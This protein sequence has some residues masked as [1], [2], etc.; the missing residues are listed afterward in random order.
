[1]TEDHAESAPP[2]PGARRRILDTA[3]RLFYGEGIHSVGIDRIIAES[4]VSKASFYKYFAAKDILIAEYLARRHERSVAEVAAVSR[5]P[6][7]DAVRGVSALISSAVREPGF[8]GCAFVNA[9][10]EYPD[11]SHLVR[12]AITIHRDW[13][14]EAMWTLLREAGHPLPGDAADDFVLARDGA[15]TGGYSGDAIAAVAALERVTDR[16]LAEVGAAQ[17]RAASPDPDDDD[18]D[19]DFDDD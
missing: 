11:E 10:A 6:A 18:F 1:M 14:G 2:G 7:A 17:G 8:R 12:R 16:L 13:L 9:A 15:M 5:M 3:D 19:D 4:R